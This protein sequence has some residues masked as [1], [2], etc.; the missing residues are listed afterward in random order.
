MKRGGCCRLWHMTFL[1]LLYNNIFIVQKNTITAARVHITLFGRGG[2]PPQGLKFTRQVLSEQVIE[3]FVQFLHRDD[4]SRPSSC[5]SVLVEG[6]E[7]AVRYWQYS[8]KDI[9]HQYSMEFPN[10]VKRT[11]IY[12]HLPQNFRM[13]SMLA[14]L[15]NICDDSGHSNFEALE[16]LIDDVSTKLVSLD[17]VSLKNKVRTYQIYLKTN[18]LKQVWIHNSLVS[19]SQLYHYLVFYSMDTF[20]QTI[21]FQLDIVY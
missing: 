3:E 15:C 13:N 18:Y 7:T 21:G 20:M 9:V 17:V 14:G 16:T 11:Y 5:R 4:V 12:T 2:V 8:L 1:T 19:L 10:G 6:K